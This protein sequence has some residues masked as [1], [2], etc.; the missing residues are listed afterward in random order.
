MDDNPYEPPSTESR[1]AGTKRRSAAALVFLILLSFPAGFICG[2]VTCGTIGSGGD[3]VAQ[4]TGIDLE[5]TWYMSGIAGLVVAVAVPLGLI[6]LLLR[7]G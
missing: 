3:V 4:A 6:W 5:L 1:K 7:R 2:V